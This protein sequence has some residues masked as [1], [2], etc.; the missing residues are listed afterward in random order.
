[1]LQPTTPAGRLLSLDFLR[2]FIMVLLAMESTG[3]YEYLYEHTSGQGS[4]VFFEQLTH[5]TG[6]GCA[7]GIWCS[8]RLCLWQGLLWLIR[9]ASNGPAVSAGSSLL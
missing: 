6:T 2:G 4:N 8:L 5:H 9:S 3:L 7:S 1:M